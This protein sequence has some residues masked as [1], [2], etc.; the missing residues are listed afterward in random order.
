M[1]QLPH[2]WRD[3]SDL[4][5]LMK[6][7]VA[8][9]M[10]SV[11]V[12]RLFLI[13]SLDRQMS[14]YFISIYTWGNSQSSLTQQQ[15]ALKRPVVDLSC[16]DLAAGI[17]IKFVWLTDLWIIASG[18]TFVGFVCFVLFVCLFRLARLTPQIG[19]WSSIRK[20]IRPHEYI[21]ISQM[22]TLIKGARYTSSVVLLSCGLYLFKCCIKTA[23]CG[24]NQPVQKTALAS[25]LK[26]QTIRTFKKMLQHLF[27]SPLKINISIIN[28]NSE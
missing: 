1:R 10:S 20:S 7:W 6:L 14:L 8:V 13:H 28:A 23:S 24:A 21:Y 22:S 5:S 18:A 17:K 4:M 11:F 26:V 16:S 9:L 27:S 25:T 12:L 19:D 15:S 2:L 3:R